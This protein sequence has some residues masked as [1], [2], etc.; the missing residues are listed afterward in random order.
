MIRFAE[1]AGQG[2][3][4]GPVAAEIE[5]IGSCARRATAADLGHADIDRM[6][7]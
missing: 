6:I 3:P 4:A 1:Q 5:E 2:D 7:I